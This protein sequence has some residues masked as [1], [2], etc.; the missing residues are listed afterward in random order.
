MRVYL[1]GT[2]LVAVLGNTAGISWLAEWS[3]A[4]SE[5]VRLALWGLTLLA[6]SSTLRTWFRARSREQRQVDEANQPIP[7]SLARPA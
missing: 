3:P 4:A 5:P 7:A 2:G 1:I 6:V